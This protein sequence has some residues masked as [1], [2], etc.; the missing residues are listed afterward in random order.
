MGLGYS[1]LWL[2]ESESKER[3]R[4]FALTVLLSVRSGALPL[5]CRGGGGGWVGGWV[6]E[7]HT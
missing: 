3:K 5:D 6:G 2:V 1:T 4:I 7:H